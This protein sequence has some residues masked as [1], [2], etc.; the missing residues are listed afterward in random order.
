M[1]YPRRH[2]R[3]TYEGISFLSILAFIVLGSI[4]R[5]INLLVLLSGLMI[6]P[7]F[8][9][10]RISRKMLQQVR[11]DRQL[12]VW[13]HAGTALIVDW[14]IKNNRRRIASWEIRITDAVTTDD[15]A[16]ST[17]RRADVLVHQINPGQ[18]GSARYR[19]TVQRRG[20]VRF[21][22]AQA[23]S[24]WPL[25]LVRT[26]IRI[27]ESPQLV[28]APALGRLATGWY[29]LTRLSRNENEL[30]NRRRSGT[31][32]EDFF[33]LR[34]W[35]RGDSRRIVHWRSSA[36]RGEL[37]VRQGVEPGTRRLTVLVELAPGTPESVET[38]ASLAATIACRVPARQGTRE[39]TLGVYGDRECGPPI[40][41]VPA[42]LPKLME[43][44]ATIGPAA[45]TG[46]LT[47]LRSCQRRQVTGDQIIV[48]SNRTLA[49]ARSES[50]EPSDS[51]RT[52]GSGFDWIDIS[53]DG[54]FFELPQA[55]APVP[56]HPVV[57][58]DL[59]TAGR[60]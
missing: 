31:S 54:S 60:P 46:I 37:V 49:Q 53:T 40:T 24:A 59:V 11:V 29:Q 47:A 9:N 3:I 26:L 12:P 5:Q 57:P 48:F 52:R 30:T 21:G 50:G 28:V 36:K 1:K 55:A 6:A 45:D 41:P 35:Q 39:M 18:T 43:T 4:L 19:C 7:F 56:E 20:L 44:L 38:L 32:H 25:G 10:W 33:S 58:P 15:P 16:D 14:T 2:T 51:V 8:F 22:P 13:A 17:P 42:V 23:S 34:D 27:P